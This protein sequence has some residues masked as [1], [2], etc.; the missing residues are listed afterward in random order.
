MPFQKALSTSLSLVVALGLISAPV[1]VFGQTAAGKRVGKRV[2]NRVGNRVGKR[3]AKAQPAKQPVKAKRVVAA[4]PED[5]EQHLDLIYATYGDR[6]MKLDLFRLK[7]LKTPAPC[8]VVV[9]G[10]GWLKGDKTKFHALAQQL[11]ARGFVTAAVG[12][13]LGGEAKFPAAIHDC[14][15]SVRWLRANASKYGVDPRRIGAVG[16]SAGGHLVG[17]MAA[18][19]H[20]AQLRGSGGSADHS[21][22]LQA[23]AVMAGPLELSTGP[24]AEKSRQDPQNSNA[25]K[26]FGKTIDQAPALY[27]LASPFSHLDSKTPPMFFVV[28]E[29][30]NPSRNRAT[31]E[32][33]RDVG[34][35]ASIQTYA[36]GK[37]GCWNQHPWFDVIVDDLDAFF[38]REL[39]KPS[40]PANAT[41]ATDWGSLSFND[42]S[43]SL[44][45]DKA[46]GKKSVD[47]PRL[48][49]PIKVAYVRGDQSVKP[50]AVK[51]GV[52]TWAVSLP[53]GADGSID[54]VVETVGRPLLPTI[55]RIVSQGD[56]GVIVLPAHQA[57]AHGELLRY[58]PQPHKNTVGYWARETDWVEW[59]VFVEQPGSFQ[60]EILQGCGKG[61][62][63]RQLAVSVGKEAVEFIVEDTGHFQNFKPRN[64]GAVEIATPGIVKLRIRPRKKAKNAVMDVRRVRLIPAKS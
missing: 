26:W 57:V 27:K 45:V 24:V 41:I 47:I 56:D 29:Y 40:R 25:N 15:A 39:K 48:N 31:R 43:I 16:G 59:T 36:Y 7:E 8:V 18:A 46:A 49:N 32:R 12:Y 53:K 62:G 30:D 6:A 5:V 19:P 21:S 11:A 63:G 38:S 52:K 50:L 28:G 14:N 61:Q 34:V 3:A 37:H 23:A 44:H 54:L 64:I 4:L 58:E 22:R 20:L 9:H 13:R 17:L 10:G 42:K 51:P 33:L 55:P 35:A 2:G 1:S 60:V